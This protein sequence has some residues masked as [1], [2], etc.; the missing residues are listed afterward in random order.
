MIAPIK[1]ALKRAKLG[2]STRICFVACRA[3]LTWIIATP[4]D[5]CRARKKCLHFFLLPAVSEKRET[6]T[7]KAE[8]SREDS[9]VINYRRARAGTKK[10]YNIHSYIAFSAVRDTTAPLC[11][12]ANVKTFDDEF[13]N[14]NSTSKCLKSD[15]IKAMLRDG[16]KLHMRRQPP[17]FVITISWFNL[18]YSQITRNVYAR[19]FLCLFAAWMHKKCAR[20]KSYIVRHSGRH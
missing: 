14:K 5:K 20:S 12:Y 13:D 2:S 10:L 7:Q 8:F 15:S 16:T 9:F 18:K 6:N 19:V 4:N 11:L 1:N 3:V 17:Q